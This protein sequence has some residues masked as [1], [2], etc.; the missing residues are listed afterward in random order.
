MSETATPIRGER[1]SRGWTQEDLAR[2]LAAQGVTVS[3]SE[4]S[5]IERG[6]AMPWP[7]LRAALARLLNLDI[8]LKKKATDQR[9]EGEQTEGDS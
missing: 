9:A 3:G 4:I 5:R 8:D 6:L 1:L 7:P 2:H